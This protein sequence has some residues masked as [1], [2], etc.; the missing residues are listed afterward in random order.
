[1]NTIVT[2]VRGHSR[3]F[4]LVPFESLGAVSYSNS[5][6]TMAVSVTVY[7]HLR[8]VVTMRYSTSNYSVTS[9]TSSFLHQFRDKAR[10]WSKIVIFSYPLHS[11]PPLGGRGS[12]QNI[13]IPFGVE[14]LEWWGYP[15]VKNFEDMCNRLG[16]IPACERRTDRQ[17]D[18]Q[19]SCH[20]IVR[21]NLW[22][23]NL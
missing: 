7:R 9:K 12:G 17:T 22:L 23:S 14:K 5:I 6:V 13:A 19:T 8:M 10:Y 18:G 4:K 20:G 21:A 11:A 2:W 16:T 3:S 1:M 15:T